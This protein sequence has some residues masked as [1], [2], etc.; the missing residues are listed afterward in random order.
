MKLHQACLNLTHAASSSAEAGTGPICTPQTQ[1]QSPSHLCLLCQ[2]AASSNPGLSYASSMATQGFHLQALSKG[3][4]SHVGHQVPQ[5]SCCQCGQ[6]QARS[7]GGIDLLS[8]DQHD[9]VVSEAK[10]DEGHASSHC[11]GCEG[12]R[13]WP[14]DGACRGCILQPA[15][16]HLSAR[17]TGKVFLIQACTEHMLLA[18]IVTWSYA[19]PSHMSST[20]EQGIAGEP[21][22][23][24]VRSR[25]RDSSRHQNHLLTVA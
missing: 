14:E 1:Q 6:A 16:L 9:E 22:T 7:K 23:A 18:G 12:T 10:G 17:R 5:T 21:G 2:G 24:Q 25:T 8:S 4:A 3:Q 11:Q 19:K 13:A 20:G 15:G